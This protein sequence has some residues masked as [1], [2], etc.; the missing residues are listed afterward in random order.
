MRQ[1]IIEALKAKFVGVSEKI[2]GR[3]ADK[4][5]KTVTTAEEVK[6]AVDG[7]TFQQVLDSYGDSRATEAQQSAVQNYEKKYGL[8]EGKVVKVE[9]TE[10]HEEHQ[11]SGNGDEVPAWAKALIE[12]NKALGEQVKAMQGE[13]VTANRRE[14]LSKI[15]SSLPAAVR[16]AYERTPVDTLT[17]EEFET[18]KAEITTEAADIAKETT[19]RGAVFGRPSVQ[20]GTKTQ[21]TSAD[22]NGGKEATEDEAKAVVDKLGI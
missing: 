6:T 11:P 14:Q 4:L 3:I 2:L 16:K 18:L 22:G 10:E 13:R 20:G 12:S 1:Q 9:T 8:K 7:V 19:A 15:T 21:Q 5:A 17:D